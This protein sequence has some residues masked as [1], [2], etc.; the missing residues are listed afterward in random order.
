MYGITRQL[1]VA[2]SF[3]NLN[4]GFKSLLFS[5]N[6]NF[7]NEEH[8]NLFNKNTKIPIRSNSNVRVLPT[9]DF[10]ILKQIKINLEPYGQL[11]R[12]DK[13]IGEFPHEFP[14]NSTSIES[15]N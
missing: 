5:T 12:I 4:T 13:P 7:N 2:N 15:Q 14:F 11:M 10:K 1:F 6:K 8:N 3:K 9:C